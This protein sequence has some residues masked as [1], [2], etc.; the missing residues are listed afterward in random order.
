MTELIDGFDASAVSGRLRERN[1]AGDD[2]SR[3]GFR[4]RDVHGVVSADVVSQPPRST[5][6]IEMGMTMEIEVGE[7]RNRFV[8]TAGKE[9][10]GSHKTPQALNH[11]DVDEVRRVEFVTPER[12][13]LP[14]GRHVRSGAET[15]AA[16][17]RRRQSRRLALLADDHRRR[18]L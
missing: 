10:S 16:P 7:I 3:N 1:V 5:Q 13:G 6:K 2:R 4:E 14:L 8:G 17:T 11:L 15:P 12:G 18:G 9:F